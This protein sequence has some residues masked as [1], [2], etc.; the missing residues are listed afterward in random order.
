MNPSVSANN[1]VERSPQQNNTDNFC[2]VNN[3]G[4]ANNTNATNNRAVA[5]GFCTPSKEEAY[6]GC[7]L[8][9]QL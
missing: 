7:F 5:P 9:L 8:T 6:I 2:M 4:N 3:N 1:C